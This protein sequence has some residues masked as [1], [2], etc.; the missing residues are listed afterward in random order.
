MY[1]ENTRLIVSLEKVSK[2]VGVHQNPPALAQYIH[3]LFH[4]LNLIKYKKCIKSIK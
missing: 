3:C 1:L 4:K 2:D